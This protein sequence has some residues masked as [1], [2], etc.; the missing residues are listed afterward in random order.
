MRKEMVL[1]TQTLW[2]R[3]SR[4]KKQQESRPDGWKT[5]V[6]WE[7]SLAVCNVHERSNKK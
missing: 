2:E 4:Q 5:Q 7:K 3:L 1:D 6:C